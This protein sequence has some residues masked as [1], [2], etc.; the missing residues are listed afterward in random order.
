M[1]SYD[2]EMKG[3]DR[4]GKGVFKW[5]NGAILEG[6]WKNDKVNGRGRL[7]TA[8]GDVYIG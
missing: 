8:D 1:G 2:G 5:G 6:Y 4:D 7:V 3:K